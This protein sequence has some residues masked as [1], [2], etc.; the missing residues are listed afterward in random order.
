ML[1][2]VLFVTPA[3]RFRNPDC[4]QRRDKEGATASPPRHQNNYKAGAGFQVA[5]ACA[6]HGLSGA[7]NPLKP[8]QFAFKKLEG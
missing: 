1:K 8:A 7:E 4:R 6:L 3:L 5:L 2:R